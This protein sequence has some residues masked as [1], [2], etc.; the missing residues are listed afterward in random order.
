M[1]YIVEML[2]LKHTLLDI[3]ELLDFNSFPKDIFEN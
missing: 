1:F 2:I 3:L